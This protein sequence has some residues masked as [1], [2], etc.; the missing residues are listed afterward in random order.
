[1]IIEK[2]N[3]FGKRQISLVKPQET[4]KG[5][6]I[7]RGV[8]LT[9]DGAFLVH[10]TD[11]LETLYKMLGCSCIDIVTRSVK[12]KKFDFIIDD[13]GRMKDGNH[14]QAV[15]SLGSEVL[16]GNILIAGL[17]DEDGDLTDLSGMDL[18]RIAPS[19]Y[20]GH[21]LIYDLF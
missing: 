10:Y 16:L 12:R 17:A 5:V 21:I 11:D 4:E 1:M 7:R 20:D 6:F 14:I 9:K 13:E 3:L 8:L 18:G 2:Q 19:I 15:S